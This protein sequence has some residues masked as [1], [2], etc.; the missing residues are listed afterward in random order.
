MKASD[1]SDQQGSDQSLQADIEED[2]SLMATLTT[3]FYRGEMDRV[4]TWRARLDQT[5]NWSVVLMATI[6]T[7]S[8]SSRDNPHYLLL[9]GALAVVAFLVIEATRYQEYDAWRLRVLLLQQQLFADVFE[10]GGAPAGEWRD[11]LGSD[12]EEPTV[13]IPLWKALAH[14]LQRVYLLLLTIMLAAW[15]LRITVFET[16]EPWYQSAAIG[17]I[18]GTSVVTAVGIIYLLAV[19]LAVWSVVQS[20]Q[21]EFEENATSGTI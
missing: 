16:G 15:G 10:D 3:H 12:L 17:S 18:P 13:N 6:L 21:R 4:T 20:R 14:R 11:R 2:P 9:V 5:T 19:G 1:M 7:F 8:F